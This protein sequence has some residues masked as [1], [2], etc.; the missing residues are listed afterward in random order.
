MQVG[1]FIGHEALVKQK[2]EGIRKKLVMFLL[3]NHDVD[4]DP[5]PWGGEPI[6][7]NGQYCG[8]TTSTAFGYTLN[9][10]VCLGYVHNIDTQT[11]QRDFIDSSFVTDKSVVYEVDIAGKRFRA[12]A[13]LLPPKMPPKKRIEV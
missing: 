7:R 6:Y 11:K 10:Q 12:K 3:E 1:G 2:E 9:K 8:T 5:W 13:S 4:S